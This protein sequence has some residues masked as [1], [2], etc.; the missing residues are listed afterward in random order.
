M[1]WDLEELARIALERADVGAPVNPDLLARRRELEVFDGGPGSKGLLIAKKIYVDETQRPRRRAFT[2]G[3]EIGHDIEDEHGLPRAEWRANYLASALILPKLDF[4]ADLRRWGWD[5]IR[6]AAKHP[7]ASFECLA[8]R[9][10]AL[11]DA[12]ACVFDRP[13]AGQRKPTSYAIPWRGARPSDEER[14]AAREAIACGAPVELRPGLTAWPV[15]EHD[16]HRAITVA[17]L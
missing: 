15:L 10:V 8:R 4:E 17:S 3:H 5:L 6:L 9:I 16:W 14:T 13:L 7:H 12:R 11:R 1:H 2:V